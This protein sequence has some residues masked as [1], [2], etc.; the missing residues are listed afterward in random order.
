M[1]DTSSSQA[2]E[3]EFDALTARA[4]LTIPAARRSGYLAAFADLRL[5][6][7]LLHT[8]RGGDVEPANVFRLASLEP[9]R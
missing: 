6:L 8:T 3:A 5:Q 2:L 9:T 7:E 4:G 1:P